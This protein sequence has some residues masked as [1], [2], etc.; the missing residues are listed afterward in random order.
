MSTENSDPL[1][2]VVEDEPKL[3]QLMID[4]LQAS[5]YRTHHLADG[6]AVLSYVQQTPPDLML[7]DLMLP[8]RDG[9]TLCREIRRFSELPII[10][11]TARTEEIDRLLGLE[12]GADDY[13]CKPFSP[14]EVVARVKTI[15]R[16]VKRSPEEAQL[17]SHL[18]ID[19]GRFQASWREQPL[20]LTPAEFRLLK[21]LALEPGKVFSREQLLN[22]LYDDYRVVTDRTIDSHIKNLRRKL[23]NLDAEQPF[24]R[25]VYGMGYRWEA[26]V[27]RLL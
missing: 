27:G 24:I 18:L 14:R 15:L 17:A 22:H 5:N 7:L 16:R 4:Y 12:I 3:A 2:L 8:G 1:I 21:T 11:V 20:E 6:N 19:E 23:E 26:D 13:I 10:M 9:L 25:A